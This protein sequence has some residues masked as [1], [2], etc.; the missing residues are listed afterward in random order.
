MEKSKKQIIYLLLIL[1]GFI[2]LIIYFGHTIYSTSKKDLAEQFNNQQL[3]LANEIADGIENYFVQLNEKLGFLVSFTKVKELQQEC[4]DKMRIFY[5]QEK[6]QVCFLGRIDRYGNLRYFLSGKG[7]NRVKKNYRKEPYFIKAK[8]AREPFLLMDYQDKKNPRIIIVAPVDAKSDFLSE[9]F[10][11]NDIQ[12]AGI[13]MVEIELDDIVNTFIRPAKFGRHGFVW[14][15]DESGMLLDHIRHPE[16]VG[17]N[18]FTS[19]KSCFFCHQSFSIEKDMTKGNTGTG[20]YSIKRGRENFIAYAPIHLKDHLW[21]VGVAASVSEVEELLKVNLRNTLILVIFTIICFTTGVFLIAKINARKI[22]LEEKDR[23]GKEILRAKMELQ[24]IFD[25]ITDGITLIDRDLII[26][27][28]NKAFAKMFNKSQEEMIGKKCY[29][30]F[31]K[32]DTICPICPVEQT[33]RTG[34]PSF[35]EEILE[36]DD[37][38]KFYADVTAFPLRNEKG[39]LIQIIEYIKDTTEQH[40][41]KTRLEQSEQLASIGTFASTLAHEVKNPLNSINLQL[42]LLER[43]L[44]KVEPNIRNEATKLIEIV[45][46]ENS[47]LNKLAEDFLALSRTSKKDFLEGNVNSILDEV[48]KLIEL[49]ARDRG[50]LINKSFGQIPSFLMDAG[51]IKQ[52]FLN[53]I[54]NSLEAMSDGGKLGITTQFKNGDAIIKIEDTGIGIK[55]GERIFDIFYSTKEK[56]TGL[57]LAIAQRIIEDHNGKIEFESKPGEWTVF[58][59]IIPTKI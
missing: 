7:W 55:D 38:S 46:K 47:R 12:F 36:R 6:E 27:N 15:L 50:I 20:K 32:R 17:R 30:E 35:S 49:E 45:R 33:L 56:G 59:I 21:S 8:S 28:V 18:I 54:R 13:I 19:D 23:S 16:M 57:G 41:I 51:K 58:N 40:R 22:L 53:I 24:A 14:L 48:L 44:S 26:K 43:R 9:K 4:L 25:G 39:E 42:T 52:V 37:G 2:S 10:S 3:M 31:K 5:E 1:T 11:H 29:R 34:N